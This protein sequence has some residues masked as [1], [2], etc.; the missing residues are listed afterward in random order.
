L[1]PS[2]QDIKSYLPHGAFKI[3][4]VLEKDVKNLK[5]LLRERQTQ[6]IN[7]QAQGA[8]GRAM[9]F[10]KEIARIEQDLSNAESKVYQKKMA[11]RE[12][13]EAARKKHGK[14]LQVL[15]AAKNAN[16]TQGNQVQGSQSRAMQALAYQSSAT[17]ALVPAAA[18]ASPVVAPRPAFPHSLVG[19]LGNGTGEPGQSPIILFP[20]PTPGEYIP[21]YA[22]T[23]VAF[24]PTAPSTTVNAGMLNGGAPGAANRSAKAPGL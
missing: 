16:Q 1:N 13:I 21:Y 7:C 9:E 3:I 10:R 8:T 22:G 14:K 20:S 12:V 6:L 5:G 15:K 2:P 11:R 18:G 24:P 4:Q 23:P 17:A 19:M